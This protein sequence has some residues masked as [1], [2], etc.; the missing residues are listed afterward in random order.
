MYLSKLEIKNF[1]CFDENGIKISFNKGLTALVGAND[2]GKT[3]II[4]AI[5]YAL[6]STDQD[7]ISWDIT[8]FYKENYD[9]G[10]VISMKFEDL[11][12][13]ESSAFLEYLTYEEEKQEE[14]VKTKDSLNLTVSVIKKNRVGNRGREYFKTEMISGKDGNGKHVEKEVREMLR[15]TYLRP[16]RDAENALTAGRYSR[17]SR[18]LKYVEAINDGQSFNIELMKEKLEK[19]E[20]L[21]TIPLDLS[22]P[23]IADLT[24][25]L[26]E[27]NEK[28]KET[29]EQIDDTLKEKLTLKNDQ[30]KSKIGVVDSEAS[31]DKKLTGLLEKLNLTIE[32]VEDNY[33]KLGLGTNNLLYIACELLLFQGGEVENKLLLIEEPE[34]HIHAQRQLKIIKSLQKDADNNVQSII[35]THSPLLASVIKLKNLV[36]IQKSKA[37]TMSKDY[38]QLNTSDYGFLERFLDATKAN[39]F[40]AHSVVIVEGPAENILLPTIA[41]LLGRDFTD[42]GVSIVNVGGISLGRYSRIFQRKNDK[43]WI[44]VKVACITDLDI[45][46]TKADKICY[47][48]EE[49][50]EQGESKE[51]E[52]ASKKGKET[53]EE[54][55][56]EKEDK[57]LKIAEKYDGQNVKAFVSDN[58]TLEYDLA[59]AGLAEEIFIAAK[60]AIKDERNIPKKDNFSKVTEEAK[61]NFQGFTCLDNEELACTVYSEFTKDTKASKAIAA[62]YLANLLNERYAEN[63]E[64]LLEKLPKY[65]IEAIEHVTEKIDTSNFSGSSANS[66]S[67]EEN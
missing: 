13:E 30:I 32:R 42:Y 36:Y 59:F 11:T 14:V 51:K 65:I 48:I 45:R 49:E 31:R 16:L 28:I 24:N 2:S 46:P 17:L 38:T 1:R 50:T 40:F 41:R 34:A 35:S 19:G 54:K 37:F 33:G 44:N 47:N 25:F 43:K 21:G 66:K 61:N 56:K 7:W 15:V 27:E 4:D 18:I 67:G 5:R 3:A 10:I 29:T 55:E 62:Q 63:Q 12:K 23:G 58:W 9:N 39:L 8:D 20:D 60:Q 26:L 64:K 53:K 57:R 6:G 52:K 22:V